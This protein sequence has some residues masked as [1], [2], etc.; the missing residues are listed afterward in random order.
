MDP[1]KLSEKKKSTSQSAFFNLG[2]LIR[3]LAILAGAFLALFVKSAQIKGPERAVNPMSPSGGVQEEWV[4]RY[5]GPRNGSDEANAIAIDSA[6]NVYVTGESVGGYYDYTTV[7]YDSFGQEQWVA[8]YNGPQN[9]VDEAHA[10]AIDSAGNVY[11][12]GES[13]G[14]GTDDD[15]ATVKYDSSGQEQWVARYNGPGNGSDEANA[16]ALDSAGNVY[17]TG[18]SVGAGNDDDYATVKYDSSGQEQW[19]AR[20]NGPG[21]GVDLANAIALDSAGNVYVTGGSE[22]LGIG[23]DYATIK[24]VQGA[25]PTPTP[26]PITLTAS[27]RKVE[28]VNTVRLIWSGATSTNIDVYRNGTLILSTANDG[29]YVDSTG[30]TGRA[31]YTYRVCETGTQTCS[32]DA[33]VT[34]GQ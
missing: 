34:F 28:G 9:S 12:T 23:F 3:L 17:V 25:T 20:Y 5:D 14:L 18:K 32:N 6:G 4:A 27:G 8:R 13:V 15:Y 10:I 21:N 22:G 30:D 26:G 29:L 33:R 19:V 16:I 11:V 31:T 24:Y 7:K 1:S 2:V